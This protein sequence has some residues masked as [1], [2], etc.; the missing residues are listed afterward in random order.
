MSSGF[1]GFYEKVDSGGEDDGIIYTTDEYRNLDALPE[2]AQEF[3]G[4]TLPQTLRANTNNLVWRQDVALPIYEVDCD[5]TK[6]VYPMVYQN[7]SR[8]VQV[9]FGVNSSDMGYWLASEDGA[10]IACEY[11]AEWDFHGLRIFTPMPGVAHKITLT[12]VSPG[13]VS[14]IPSK[15]LPQGSGGDDVIIAELQHLQ[16]DENKYRATLKD[17]DF[18]KIAANITSRVLFYIEDKDT[19]MY[20]TPITTTMSNSNLEFICVAGDVGNLVAIIV[21]RY[22]D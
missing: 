5:G 15:Y 16:N 8:V 12:D 2:E 11:T 6:R 17:E 1:T 20:F 4:T 18:A 7:F 21:A 13:R 3:F 19:I 9:G 22:A 10:M 14:Q